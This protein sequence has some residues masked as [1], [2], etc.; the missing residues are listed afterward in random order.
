MS[1]LDQV[2]AFAFN[3]QTIIIELIFAII[4]GIVVVWLFTHL[5]GEG[6]DGKGATS[7]AGLDDIEQALKRVLESTDIKV[8][9]AQAVRH[10]KDDD[11]DILLVPQKG[12]GP[13]GV[14]PGG[15]VPDQAELS[16]LRL[17]MEVKNKKISEVEQA[18]NQAKAELV[19]A[20]SLSTGAPE[21]SSAVNTDDLQAKIRSLESRLA[22]YEII[23]DDIANLSLYKEENI[24][25]KADLE[26]LKRG[27]GG[28]DSSS[29][30][31]GASAAHLEKTQG[32]VMTTA[33]APAAGQGPVATEIPVGMS[34]KGTPTT[35]TGKSES[36]ASN[37]PMAAVT[38]PLSEE[39]ID[40]DKLLKEFDALVAQDLTRGGSL[41]SDKVTM[42]SGGQDPGPARKEASPSQGATPPSATPDGEKLIEEFENFVKGSNS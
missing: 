23:E 16:R 33:A 24:K 36:T 7:G 42:G 21:G 19:K 26:K 1:K 29:A 2:L 12:P 22:E 4:L 39:P 37:P 31:S 27:A 17:E 32:P 5:R 11:D 40:S 28:L 9:T 8:T 13:S 14:T 6:E 38:A 18:L 10:I 34:E 3:H 15:V 41:L 25:L 30:L 20:Q 35:T